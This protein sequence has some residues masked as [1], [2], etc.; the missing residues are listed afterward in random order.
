[1]PRRTHGQRHKTHKIY[2]R[3]LINFKKKCICSPT[4]LEVRSSF[5]GSG[6]RFTFFRRSRLA[7]QPSHAPIQ[8]IPGTFPGP[9]WPGREL[10]THF[11]LAIR[12]RICGGISLLPTT[13]SRR[14][15][16]QLY[17]FYTHIK[18]D[19]FVCH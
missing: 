17:L 9:Y 15:Q 18:K 8:W 1:M 14:G 13:Y 10:I 3:Q 5:L 19:K 16:R 11:Y 7:L 2:F 12:L 6:K 4:R